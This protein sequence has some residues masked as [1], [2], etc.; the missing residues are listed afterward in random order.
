M[1][2][3]PFNEITVIALKKYKLV[4]I[5]RIYWLEFLLSYIYF[6]KV[7]MIVARDVDRIRQTMGK[8]PPEHLW[9]G[10]QCCPGFL[11]GPCT[12]SHARILHLHWQ[13][14]PLHQVQD[15]CWSRLLPGWGQ[16]GVMFPAQP[17]LAAGA[18]QTREAAG[19]GSIYLFCSVSTNYFMM[20]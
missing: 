4:R 5:K 20:V 2:I 13:H 9:C 12:L 7:C 11:Q 14:F 18:S 1:V 16:V 6:F 10:W 15:S 8:Q 17:L 19:T 3:M